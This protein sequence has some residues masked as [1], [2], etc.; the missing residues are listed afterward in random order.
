MS[1]IKSPMERAPKKL[2]GVTRAQ[3]K[4]QMHERYRAQAHKFYS[5]SEARRARA[6]SQS[7]TK[8]RNGFRLIMPPVAWLGLPPTVVRDPSKPPYTPLER[9]MMHHGVYKWS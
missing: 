7:A 2:A 9:R 8:T 6:G 5:R 3:L 4:R 1:D